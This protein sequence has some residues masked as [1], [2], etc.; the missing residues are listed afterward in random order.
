M[1]CPIAPG[2]TRVARKPAL[3]VTSSDPL[4][5]DDLLAAWN[6]ARVSFSSIYPTHAVGER[7]NF[8]T[9]VLYLL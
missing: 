6:L 1:E 2:S 4:L 8:L 9:L 7:S 3:D 5:S